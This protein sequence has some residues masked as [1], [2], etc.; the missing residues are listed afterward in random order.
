MNKNSI[1]F[2]IARLATSVQKMRKFKMD[3][4][5]DIDSK[6]S[7]LIWYA[8]TKKLFQCHILGRLV[9]GKTVA[10]V[11]ENSEFAFL[12]IYNLHFKSKCTNIDCCEFL[13]PPTHWSKQRLLEEYLLLAGGNKKTVKT[14][15]SEPTKRKRGRPS[16]SLSIKVERKAEPSKF[17]KSKK[18]NSLTEVKFKELYTK[19][20]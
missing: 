5:A 13:Q 4:N 9:H 14:A 16:N 3:S 11:I 18:P 8:P 6:T 17:T 15:I 2:K 12:K 1:D 19:I 10:E 7:M 20:N